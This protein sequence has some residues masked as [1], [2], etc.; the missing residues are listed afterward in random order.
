MKMNLKWK[1]DTMQE[2]VP[3]MFHIGIGQIYKGDSVV[4]DSIIGYVQNY[5]TLRFPLK[6]EFHDN[7]NTNIAII[8]D[9]GKW[10]DSESIFN[11]SD[12]PKGMMQNQ[13]A[14][15][16]ACLNG[17]TA[18]SVSVSYYPVWGGNQ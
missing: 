2:P 12:Y 9:I 6:I 10:F 14:M 11:F 3:F 4:T 15:H 18:F 5:F 8:M 1:N 13:E 7:W 16:K 17:R